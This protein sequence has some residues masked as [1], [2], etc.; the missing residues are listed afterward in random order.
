ML[1][2]SKNHEIGSVK[3]YMD[4]IGRITKQNQNNINFKRLNFM[5]KNELE[6]K[7]CILVGIWLVHFFNDFKKIESSSEILGKLKELKNDYPNS[8]S[9]WNFLELLFDYLSEKNLLESVFKIE[10][11]NLEDILSEDILGTMLQQALT[12]ENR[13][14]LAVN[15]TT[16]SSAN[17][18]VSILDQKSFSTIIDPFCGSGRLISAYL[19]KLDSDSTFPQIRIND[20]MASAVLLAYSRIT[21]ILSKLNKNL[22]LLHASIGDAFG[23]VFAHNEETVELNHYDLV[24]MNPPFT[25]IHRIEHTQKNH[26][27]KLEG[28]YNHFISGQVGLHVFSLFLADSFLKKGGTVASILPASTI[29]SKYSK[30]VHNLLLKRYE[31]NIIAASDNN[32]SCSEDSNLRE[33]YLTAKRVDRPKRSKVNFLRILNAKNSFNWNILSKQ[34][35]SNIQLSK[36]WNWTIFLRE[37]QLLYLRKKLLQTKFVKS[38]KDLEMDIIRGVEMYGPDFFFIPNQNWKILSE[39]KDNLIIIS[40]NSGDSKN[41]TIA[42]PKNYLIRILRRPGKYNHLISPRVNDFAISLPDSSVLSKNWLKK[43]CSVSEH[44]AAPAKKKFGSKWISHINH[45]LTKKVPYGNLFLIDKSGITTTGVMSHFF[46]QKLPCTKNFYLVRSRSIEQAKL[47]A[48]WLNSTFFIILFLMCR[49]EI[50]GSY[51]RLQIMDYMEESLFLDVSK[52]TSQIKDDIIKEFEKMRNN[53]L[54]AI[55]FQIEKLIKK[56]LDF[57]IAKGLKFSEKESEDLLSEMYSILRNVFKNLNSRDK[58]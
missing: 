50:G 25:R 36:E 17:V 9:I 27:K 28:Q 20:I 43:Y 23:L 24:I 16:F 32:K 11:P 55:P 57:A 5:I 37:P 12:P 56:D 39:K 1:I 38:G 41:L 19:M 47:L 34:V 10:L 49:R 2:S 45:Q 8:L 30:G 51:G 18:L 46:D 35:I 54:P 21:L 3:Y 42:L 14:K 13:K 22:N 58:I 33:I 40:R 53:K 52:L 7:I 48:A 31:I 4:K 26:L 44:L 6:F 29:L 15:Y